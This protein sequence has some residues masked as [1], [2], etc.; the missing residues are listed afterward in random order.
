MLRPF[1]SCVPASWCTLTL[2]VPVSFPVSYKSDNI[3][4]VEATMNLIERMQAEMLSLPE[5]TFES[6]FMQDRPPQIVFDTFKAFLLMLGYRSR[7]VQVHDSCYIHNIRFMDNNFLIISALGKASSTHHGSGRRWETSAAFRRQEDPTEN[8]RGG[9][10]ADWKYWRSRLGS[11]AA[12]FR[13]L[14][15]LDKTQLAHL[16]SRLQNRFIGVFNSCKRCA[17]RTRFIVRSYN[18]CTRLHLRISK[19]SS[20]LL[21]W[22][23]CR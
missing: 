13:S 8:R 11:S 15:L 4:D 7:H 3:R 2:H 16:S 20:E 6:F 18:D 1:D 19:P 5:N 23:F 14:L 17:R 9:S 12:K 21:L 10:G 22:P